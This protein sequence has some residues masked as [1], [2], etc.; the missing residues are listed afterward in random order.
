MRR[1]N[2]CIMHLLKE[3]EKALLSFEFSREHIFCYLPEYQ[4]K[5]NDIYRY[6][7]NIFRRIFLKR[8]NKNIKEEISKIIG[9]LQMAE[10]KVLNKYKIL[11]L[12]IK[13]SK[14][15]L[16]NTDII[17]EFEN[18]NEE[19]NFFNNLIK[20]KSLLEQYKRQI[21]EL[22]ELKSRINSLYEKII[23]MSCLDINK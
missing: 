18:E 4:N 12:Y 15:D 2:N 10:Q 21:A 11:L 6:F 13:L 20:R 9:E 19:K 5:F 23:S 17:L 22:E 3:E 8:P 14:M 7:I 16:K 1:N